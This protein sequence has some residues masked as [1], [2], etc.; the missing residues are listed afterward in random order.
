[1]KIGF[2]TSEYFAYKTDN[3]K[4]IPSNLH[5]GFGYLSRQKCEEFAKRGHEVHVF[6]PAR[7]FLPQ[8]VPG[9][10][11]ES[12]E[13]IIEINKVVVHLFTTTNESH[14][15][16]VNLLSQNFLPMSKEESWIRNV[17]NEYPVDIY[18]TEEPDVSSLIASHLNENQVVVF[19]D[20]YDDNDI[21]L[22]K[23]ARARYRKYLGLSLSR[24]YPENS[25]TVAL[26]Y[27][28]NIKRTR[29]LTTRLIGNL[30]ERNI[31]AAAEFI[32]EKVQRMYGL[33]HSP[34][35]LPNPT[36]VPMKIPEKSS[37]PFILFLAR[38][39]PVKRIDIALETAR[40]LPE[41]DFYFVG[42]PS[43][44]PIVERIAAVLR[45]RYNKYPNI[46]FL[47]FIDESVKEKLLSQTWIM[48]NTSV[49]EGLP[50]IFLEAMANGACIVSSVNP[51]HYS[52]KFGVF[53]Q[54]D[55]FV[56]AINAA[57]RKR[58]HETKGK[59]GYR[60]VKK[61]HS[62]EIVIDR[63]LQIYRDILLSHEK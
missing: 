32:G 34:D 62:T 1:M 23:T 52:D 54:D 8:T 44:N 3:G 31:F 58:L 40:R 22:Q 37:K 30:Q 45:M 26:Y 28:K 24:F 56:S 19:Q 18:Q 21:H 11:K 55:N 61:V 9:N 15:S 35:F 49:R 42:S 48:L 43:K 29:N 60:H 4:L 5:G 53:V 33:S 39:D 47:G 41:Y 16:F 13:Y 10:A 59:N 12:K 17:L 7:N 50:A 6:M 36:Y 25:F 46:H 38:W 20:P 14:H 51:D 2:L 63:H 27:R 57:V